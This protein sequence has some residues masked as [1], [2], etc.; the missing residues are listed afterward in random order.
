MALQKV[1]KEA[2]VEDLR[3][4]VDPEK[5]AGPSADRFVGEDGFGESA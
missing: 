1:F 4:S 3:S 2:Y 5:Y